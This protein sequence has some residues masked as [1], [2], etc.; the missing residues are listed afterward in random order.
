MKQHQMVEQWHFALTKNIVANEIF[1]CGELAVIKNQ[2]G[3]NHENR[4]H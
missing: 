1:Y 3:L 2:A 4:I